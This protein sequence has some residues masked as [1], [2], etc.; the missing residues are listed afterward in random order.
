M[1][2]VPLQCGDYSL[3][4]KAR[5]IRAAKIDMISHYEFERYTFDGLYDSHM[6]LDYLMQ[7]DDCEQIS[8]LYGM[9]ITRTC[10]T[11]RGWIMEGR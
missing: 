4:E 7:M 9:D 5:E 1:E 2:L 8:E 11:I 10:E 6:L 3:N